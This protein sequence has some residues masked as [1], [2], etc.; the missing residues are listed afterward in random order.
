LFALLNSTRATGG[1]TS[2]SGMKPGVVEAVARRRADEAEDAI[3]VR[4]EVDV[5]LRGA[6]TASSR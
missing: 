6:G 1:V 2:K 4:V 3:P 5:I